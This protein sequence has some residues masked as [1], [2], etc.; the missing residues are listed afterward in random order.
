MPDSAN[1]AAVKLKNGPTRFRSDYRRRPERLL[2]GLWPLNSLHGMDRYKTV[3]LKIESLREAQ[4]KAFEHYADL[5]FRLK[6]NVPIFGKTFEEVAL[7]YSD[8]LKTGIELGRITAAYWKVVDAYI[9]NHL[10]EYCGK[11][12]IA[13]MG[14]EKWKEYPLWRKRTGKGARDE[15]VQDGTIR[16]ELITFR[17]I[18][19]YA[20][21]KH[22]LPHTSVPKGKVLHS[23]AR[24]EAFTPQEYRH[25][26]T[27][28]RKWVSPFLEEDPRH[29]DRLQTAVQ[30]IQDPALILLPT[31][32]LRHV[33]THGRC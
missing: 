13:Q 33:P 1:A 12:Q 7:K 26:H 15:P 4:D 30:F 24:R 19:R 5:R 20:A 9:R 14:E 22:L 8:E 6:H 10:I 28:A 21:D 2:R 25:L 32:H 16:H 11:I 27:Y 23:K 18:L 3:A 29:P 17:A 31:P